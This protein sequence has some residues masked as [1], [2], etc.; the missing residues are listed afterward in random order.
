MLTGAD[1]HMWHVAVARAPSDGFYLCTILRALQWPS[2]SEGPTY[3]AP[4]PTK[5]RNPQCPCAGEI[6]LVLW[7]VVGL[8]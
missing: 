7:S 8:L 2:G 1:G 5:P 3:P 6:G 4:A